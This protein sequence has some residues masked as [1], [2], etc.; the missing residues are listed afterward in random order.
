MTTPCRI[1]VL[2]ALCAAILS[3]PAWGVPGDTADVPNDVLIAKGNSYLENAVSAIIK[4]S[5]AAWKYDV[6]VISDRMLNKQDRRDYQAIILFR[7]IKSAA[8]GPVSRK[9][10]ESLGKSTA[11]SNLL[12]CTVFGEKWK[13][14]DQ[15]AD[16]VASA[17]KTLRPGIV[18]AKILA[19]VRLILFKNTSH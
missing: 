9:F 12:I 8:L 3:G 16:A 11:E 17:T 18:A 1:A 6:T 5:L 19:E 15:G 13:S 10:V 14:G 2:F 4:D 7:A